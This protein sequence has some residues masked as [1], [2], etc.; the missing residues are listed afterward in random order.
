VTKAVVT[1]VNPPNLAPAD[2]AHAAAGAVAAG[3]MDTGKNPWPKMR[4]A[5]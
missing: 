5:A 2:T 4:L 1:I 3:L